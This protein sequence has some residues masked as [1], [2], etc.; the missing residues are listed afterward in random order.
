[1]F[2]HLVSLQD[3]NVSSAV[4]KFYKNTYGFHDIVGLGTGPDA[5]LYAI[6]VD[7]WPA[8]LSGYLPALIEIDPLA[9]TSS[10]PE[11]LE[12][13]SE[14][15]AIA[16]ATDG[17]QLYVCEGEDCGVFKTTPWE[18][19]LEYINDFE[20][21]W[22][23]ITVFEGIVY[24]TTGGPNGI[25]VRCGDNKNTNLNQ[26]VN[27]LHPNFTANWKGIAVCDG[28]LYAISELL[29]VY[30]FN[31]EEDRFVHRFCLHD[32]T[33]W[34][35]GYQKMKG[36]G[37]Y[38]YL[39]D[40]FH[41]LWRLDPTDVSSLTNISEDLDY[42]SSICELEGKMYVSQLQGGIYEYIP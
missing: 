34:G 41:K 42:I 24:A 38:L 7:N 39:I 27:V 1:M 10:V 14:D 36:I 33:I 32:V 23:A 40:N 3:S 4:K 37:N 25:I 9:I 17:K 16:I 30:I 8:N 12:D 13:L 21:E 2:K 35:N 18:D 26:T 29:N 15:D 22:S 5:R 28:N 11:L 31:K 19:D 6:T 20:G